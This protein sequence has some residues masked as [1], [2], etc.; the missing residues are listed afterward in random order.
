MVFHIVCSDIEAVSPN[1]IKENNKLV[2][3]AH[4]Y[5]Y[6]HELC[7]IYILNVHTF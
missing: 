1:A 5:M 6:I 4:K 7:I 3:D 2:C